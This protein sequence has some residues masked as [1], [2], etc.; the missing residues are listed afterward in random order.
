MDIGILAQM[1]E[2]NLTGISKLIV[3]TIQEI[4]KVDDKNRYF[5]LGEERTLPIKLNKIN[6]LFD[7]NE[8]IKMDYMLYTHPLNI[9]HSFCRPFSFSNR[10]CGK[11]LTINDLRPLTHPEWGAKQ[12]REYFDG[13]IRKTAIEADV[14]LAISEYTKKDIIEYYHVPEEKVKVVYCG[15]YPENVFNGKAKALN[16]SDIIS[17][18]YILSVCAIDKNKNQEGTIRAFALFKQR[19]RE[20]NLKL[21]LVGPIRNAEMFQGVLKEF[22]DVR[23][24]IIYTGYVSDEELVWLYHNAYAFMYASYYEGFGLPILEALSTGC[25]VICSNATSMPEVGG[26]AVEYCNPYSVETI[27]DAI[28]NVVLN[29]SRRVE[30][31]EKALIQA[32]KFSYKRAA[33]ETLEI[34]RMFQ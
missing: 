2:R 5:F 16:R 6:I 1:K 11:I 29:E 17:G 31:Q 3:G 34:Y 32:Q 7:N 28:E 33:E 22:P 30:L 10:G 26:D 4:M 9:V 23:K 18:N 13:P 27:V 19:N 14:I 25:A 24:D 15:L 8:Q 12:A 21:V 20:C